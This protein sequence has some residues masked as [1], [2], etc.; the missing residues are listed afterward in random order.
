MLGQL[1]RSDE[2]GEHAL[3]PGELAEPGFGD[4]RG[5]NTGIARDQEYR[6]RLVRACHRYAE[7][8]RGHRPRPAR[9]TFREIRHDAQQRAPELPTDDPPSG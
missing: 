2:G 9:S 6:L 4:I 8:A 1:N 5:H 3:D 7:V